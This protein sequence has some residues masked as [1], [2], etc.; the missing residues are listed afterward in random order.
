MRLWLSKSSEVPLR[1]QL[2]TQIILGIASNDLP[3]GQRLPSTRELA[4]RYN[5]HA[6]TVSAAYRELSRRGWVE[7]R[8]GSGVYISVRKRQDGKTR[9]ELD[10]LISDFF[11]QARRHG[12]Q[13]SEIQ[14]A[15]R[16]WSSAQPPNRF[17]LIDP[18]AELRRILRT[19][20]EQATAKRV[21][22]VGIEDVNGEDIEPGAVFV[23]LQ[24]QAENVR[25]VLPPGSELLVISS[26]SVPKS[27]HGE[28]VPPIEALISVVSC[29]PG[30][31]QRA[32]A[33]LVAAGVDGEALSLRDA[34]E[35]GWQKGLSKSALVITD[36][37]M[38]DQLPPDCNRRV[39]RILSNNSA[40]ELREYAERFLH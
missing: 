29:W 26:Q 31:L 11:Q 34:R 3:D 33:V 1:E 32:R 13:L 37:V 14:A 39:F 6:N 40:T 38:A 5:V 2:V 24:T 12:Y 22:M 21:E 15:L 8:R 18:D 23:S 25:K 19:E 28:K 10:D 17:V 35:T 27:M 9:A 36:S 4:R 30:F 7:F 16:R 20:I